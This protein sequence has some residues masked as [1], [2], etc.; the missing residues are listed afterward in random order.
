MPEQKM[1]NKPLPRSFPSPSHNRTPPPPRRTRMAGDASSI[2]VCDRAPID[3][4][5]PHLPPA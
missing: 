4:R 2:N 3:P 1:S 5:M